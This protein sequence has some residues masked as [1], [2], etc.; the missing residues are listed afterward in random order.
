MKKDQKKYQNK[1]KVKS[2]KKSAVDQHKEISLLE[3]QFE[4][5]IGIIIKSF[6][7]ENDGSYNSCIAVNACLLNI[8]I[9]FTKSLEKKE[10]LSN[11]ANKALIKYLISQLEER[12]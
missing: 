3:K 11:G 6:L 10:V 8:A 7:L 2:E 1:P 9:N 4:E 5:R 12:D